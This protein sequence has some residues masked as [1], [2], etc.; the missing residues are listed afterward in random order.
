MS[1]VDKAHP[2]SQGAS[3]SQGDKQTF[4]VIFQL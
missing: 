4:C 2:A 3:N 1:V